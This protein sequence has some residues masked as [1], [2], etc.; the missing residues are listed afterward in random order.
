LVNPLA[1]WL[2]P[3]TLLYTGLRGVARTLSGEAGIAVGVSASK[4]LFSA[5]AQ[6][7]QDQNIVIDRQL[8]QG[9]LEIIVPYDDDTL[10]KLFVI[11]ALPEVAFIATQWSN[12]VKREQFTR[13]VGLLY[14]YLSRTPKSSA[15]ALSNLDLLYQA[16]GT[17]DVDGAIWKTGYDEFAYTMEAGIT[18]LENIVKNAQSMPDRLNM[19]GGSWTFSESSSFYDDFQMSSVEDLEEII[20]GDWI[21][22]KQR[23]GQP[24]L[25][26]S[27][28]R[29]MSFGE[30]NQELLMQT[31]IATYGDEAIGVAYEP[32]YYAKTTDGRTVFA[33]MVE[34]TDSYTITLI[35]EPMTIKGGKPSKKT[36]MNLTLA[37]NDSD[38]FLVSSPHYKDI[39]K[40]SFGVK[41]VNTAG[42]AVGTLAGRILWVDTAILLGTGAVSLFVP[43]VK[44]F[45]PVGEVVS[46]LF[47]FVGSV[48]DLN[49][50]E[51][52]PEFDRI[53]LDAGIFGV[54]SQLFALDEI[55]A[56]FTPTAESVQRDLNLDKR[57]F[58]IALAKAGI[59]GAFFSFKQ[60]D[61]W[62][63]LTVLSISLLIIGVLRQ[64]PAFFRR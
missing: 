50:D 24:Y 6:M 22:A 32:V 1:L 29:A 38:E 12:P 23:N 43:S 20:D 33:T 63:V 55:S 13:S 59:G 30:V 58:G 19:R 4:A 60:Y 21:K 25:F 11:S 46:G 44:P 57:T 2:V 35:D 31:E 9:R 39:K 64:V 56:T 28:K 16:Q 5:T 3:S 17:F 27:T 34:N 26:G 15:V 40:K 54:A 49:A 7:K 8:E 18:S 51:L 62:K 47:S 61:S 48:L 53:N 52:V 36:I 45:S 42:K 41:P 10:N 14:S 37:V